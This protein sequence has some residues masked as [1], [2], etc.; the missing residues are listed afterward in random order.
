MIDKSTLDA[1]W[2]KSK[3]LMFI[4]LAIWF[5]FAYLIHMFVTSLNE[6]S[7]LGFPLGYYV[8]AQGSLFSFVLLVAWF[9]RKQNKIDEEFG[10]SE[11][12]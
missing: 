2:K 10:L 8:A 5:F 6:I 4:V 7:F 9:A 3:K 1:H 11:D 12:D